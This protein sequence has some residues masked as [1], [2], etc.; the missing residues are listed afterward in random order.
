LEGNKMNPDEILAQLIEGQNAVLKEAAD[1]LKTV[2]NSQTANKLHGINGLWSTPGL[3]REV[4]TAHVRP[5]GFASM[6]PALPSVTEDP[7]FASLT[8]IT[9]TTGTQ[10]TEPC[11]DAPYAFMKGCNLTARFG[12]LRFDTNTIDISQTFRQVNRSDFKDLVLRGRLL[13][14]TDLHPQELSES[15][16]LDVLTKAE[17]VVAG[18]SAERELSKQMWQGITTVAGNFPGLDVQIA[19]G[20]KDADSSVLCPALDSDIK[21]FAYDLVGGDGRDIVEYLSMLMFYLENNA[22]T[23]GLDPVSFAIVMRPGLWQE[24]SAVWPIVYNTNRANAVPTGATLFV[25]GRDNISD[26]DTMRSGM[27]IDINGKRYPV[28]VDTGIYEHNNINDANL[29]AGEYASSIYVVPLSITG[30]M[31]VTY[32]EFLDFRAGDNDSALLRGMN[33][34][35]T[36]SGVYSWAVENNKWCYKLSLRTEQRVILRTPQLAGKIQHVKYVPLQH[37]R[38]P[39]PESPYFADGGV[40]LR[41]Y[42]SGDAVWL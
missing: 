10:P 3:D 21:D 2:G 24:L 5:H 11:D 15:Q 17:M 41:D 34:F 27:F 40:S 26:R 13:G 37:L 8:G 25:D 31:P 33:T 38:D 18:I 35:W 29:L 28:V 16:V 1:K 32:R 9:E 14:L 6:L 39:Y 7:R 19:T 30:N 22:M 23:M 12:I 42:T 36:D 4:I 20:Q